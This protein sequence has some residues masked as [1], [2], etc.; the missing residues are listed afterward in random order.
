MDIQY[1]V[2][3]EFISSTLLSPQARQRFI[4]P[5]FD[6]DVD[7]AKLTLI[8]TLKADIAS[9]ICMH[10]LSSVR[11]VVHLRNVMLIQPRAFG[12]TAYQMTTQFFDLWILA[13][14]ILKPFFVVRYSL[15][16]NFIWN[17]EHK[18]ACRSRHISTLCARCC[19][20]V[21]WEPWGGRKHTFELYSQV[22][23]FSSMSLYITL[24]CSMNQ[25][26]KWLL[27]L[28]LLDNLVRKLQFVYCYGI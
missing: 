19:V 6:V 13:I 10:W 28:I 24:L 20:Y 17:V 3:T 1:R 27:F 22:V 11:V 9:K 26:L 15:M 12:L 25:R 8:T 2:S 4:Q 7:W 23:H 14:T 5:T 18:T 16:L 21:A